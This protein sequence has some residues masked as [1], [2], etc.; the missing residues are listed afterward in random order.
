MDLRADGCAGTKVLLEAG[1]ND[2]CG[3]CLLSEGVVMA[4]PMLPDTSILLH[5]FILKFAVIH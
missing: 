2:I 1:G 3:R 4:L 5:Y